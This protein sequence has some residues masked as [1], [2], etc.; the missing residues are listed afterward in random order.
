VLSD[1]LVNPVSGAVAIEAARQARQQR[2]TIWVVGLGPSLD[3]RTLLGVAS[4]TVRYQRAA[5][6]LAVEA[7][8]QDLTRRVPCPVEIY[9]GRR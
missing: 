1:G 2:T 5:G 9:W 7:I 6:I 8:Y 4:G 3:E